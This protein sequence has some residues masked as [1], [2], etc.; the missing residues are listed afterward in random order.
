MKPLVAT[1]EE[2]NARLEWFADPSREENRGPF[3]LVRDDFYD[4]P[5]PRPKTDEGFELALQVE[6]RFN[7]LVLFRES[8][9]HRAGGWLRRLHRGQAHMHAARM[10]GAFQTGCHCPTCGAPLAPAV[11]RVLAGSPSAPSAPSV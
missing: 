3:L 5:R 4:D 6:N 10:P 2:L 9:L 1:P 7:R 8:V 11:P